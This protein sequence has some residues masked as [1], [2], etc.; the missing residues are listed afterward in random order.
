MSKLNLKSILQNYEQV[1]CGKTFFYELNNKWEVNL[2][3]HKED[4]CHLIG[5]QHVYGKDKR[6]LG[7]NGYRSIIGEKI[8][9]DSLVKH[10]KKGFNYIKK[11]LEFF[12]KIYELLTTGNIVKFY[13]DR[14]KPRTTIVADFLVQ[15][16]RKEVLVYLFMRR[17]NGSQFSPVSFIVKS[18]KDTYPNQYVAG[19]ENKVITKFLISS[20][21]FPAHWGVTL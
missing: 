13:A 19:Q 5:L 15:H 20:G 2:V 1:L 16:G 6:Y 8:T 12:D 18:Q 10:N 14:V 7:A 21:T 9:I 11:R 3:F 4:F 17:E